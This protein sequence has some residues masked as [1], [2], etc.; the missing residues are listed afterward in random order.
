MAKK[1]TWTQVSSLVGEIQF[2]I[3][4]GDK[5]ASKPDYV[6]S[7]D[8]FIIRVAY[9]NETEKTKAALNST[10]IAVQSTMRSYYRKH[11]RFPFAPGKVQLVNGEGEFAL[12]VATHIDRLEEQLKAG[13]VDLAEKIRVARMFGLEV[14]KEWH[15]ALEASAV[16]NMSALIDAAASAESAEEVL[17]DTLE[18]DPFKYPAGSLDKVVISKLKII[19]QNEEI[20]GYDELTADEIREE[21]YAIEK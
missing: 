12:P 1:Q 20:E 13:Q 5:D 7:T 19:A 8:G 21:L 17:E 18:E 10:R 14:P 15:A 11:K 3:S 9:A 4:G 6:P 2:S 16:S